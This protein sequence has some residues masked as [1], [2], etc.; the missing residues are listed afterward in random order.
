MQ[1]IRRYRARF[2][3]NLGVPL[4]QRSVVL[5]AV[6]LS[7]LLFQIGA[8]PALTASES[9]RFRIV[10]VR[11]CRMAL[12]AYSDHG[13][14]TDQAVL[15]RLNVPPPLVLLRLACALLLI[16]VVSSDDAHYLR[17][18]VCAATAMPGGWFATAFADVVW[19]S[20]VNGGR[21]LAAQSAGRFAG[22]AGCDSIASPETLARARIFGWCEARPGQHSG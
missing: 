1:D 15:E 18:L 8:W 3:C 20:T 16:R 6:V 17:R 12:G 22:S 7:R 13:N 21:G 10:V 5:R 19:F 2:F 9:K 11:A 14:I 4:E